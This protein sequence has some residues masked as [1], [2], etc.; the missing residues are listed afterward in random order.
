M[1]SPPGGMESESVA[2]APAAVSDA[3]AVAERRAS[4]RIRAALHA[5]LTGVG[6]GGTLS[7]TATDIGA[8]GMYVRAPASS[9]LAVGQRYEVLLSERSA[10]ASQLAKLMG[11]GCY[12]TVVRTDRP[13]SPGGDIVGGGLRFDRPLVF[14]ESPAIPPG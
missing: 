6:S 7:C 5:K 8:G 13:A 10:E 1:L 11:E 2:C 9:G 12:A 4:G 14:W 3:A